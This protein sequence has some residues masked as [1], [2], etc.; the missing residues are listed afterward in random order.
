MLAA[1]GAQAQLTVDALDA[2]R[3]SIEADQALG[4]SV[5]DKVLGTFAQSIATLREARKVEA[6]V[7]EL[8]LDV[9]V[10]AHLA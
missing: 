2:Q 9:A 6:E 10:R 5:R 1:E 3:A 7:R 4:E 8:K